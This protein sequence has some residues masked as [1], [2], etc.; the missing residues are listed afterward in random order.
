MTPQIPL[1]NSPL[2]LK[3]VFRNIPEEGF[4]PYGGRGDIESQNSEVKSNFDFLLSTLQFL[5]SCQ[6]LQT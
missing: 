1:G 3:Y 6:T 4:I 5:L 2:D